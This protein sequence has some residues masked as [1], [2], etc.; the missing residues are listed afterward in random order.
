[1]CVCV[2]ATLVINIVVEQNCVKRCVHTR[3]CVCVCVWNCG[4]ETFLKE[5]RERYK[6]RR[7]GRKKKSRRNK[8]TNEK[9]QNQIKIDNPSSRGCSSKQQ[10]QQPVGSWKAVGKRQPPLLRGRAFPLHLYRASSSFH[11]LF[12]S[13][14]YHRR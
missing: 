2:N 13:V 7:G 9:Q 6:E 11:S 8:Q 12:I 10:Q 5:G 4:G 1:M 14:S 3:V